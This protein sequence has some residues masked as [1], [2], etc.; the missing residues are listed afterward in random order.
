[1]KQSK[2]IADR[3]RE[4]FL[5][6]DWVAQTNCKAQLIDLDWKQANT[7]IGSLNTIALLT[8]HLDYYVGGVLNVFN[9]GSLDIRDKYSFDMPVIESQD[10]WEKLRTRMWSNAEKFAAFVEQM[11]D[12]KLDEAFVDPKYG[13]Y[14]RNI[15]AMIEHCY[16]HL[17]QI[18]LLRK[19]LSNED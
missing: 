16:Y 14:R 5:S 7:K 8:F 6:G 11:P 19:L 17:G 1:M 3:F 13:D 2:Q 4:V 9:G 10:D 15:E 18:S 12:E